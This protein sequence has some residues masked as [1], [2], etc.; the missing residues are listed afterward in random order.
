MNFLASLLLIIFCLSVSVIEP[1]IEFEHIPNR[2]AN[3]QFKFNNLPSPSSTDAATKAKLTIID[4]VL[5]GG[6][7]QLG[8]LTD[9]VLPKNEDDPGGNLYF[10]AGSMG[11]R[12]LM[13]FQ[14]PIDIA[15]V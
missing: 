13:D 6:S 12:F 11:G 1:R 3:P 8:A 7:G 9:G 10:N 4:G 2:A 15:E 14:T 5:D